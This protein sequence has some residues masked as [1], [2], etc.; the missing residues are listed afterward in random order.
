MSKNMKVS[1]VLYKQKKNH[2]KNMMIRFIKW[3]D[4]NGF[5]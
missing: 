2:D 4:N 1:K 5:F 3:I